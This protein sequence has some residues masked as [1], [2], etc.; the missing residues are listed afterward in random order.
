MDELERQAL[1]R[2]RTLLLLNTRSGDPPEQFYR[3]LGYHVVGVVPDFAM[4]PDGSMNA[5]TILYRRL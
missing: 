5:T 3:A 2:G 1:V 4:N